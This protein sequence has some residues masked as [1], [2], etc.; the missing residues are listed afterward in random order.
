[1]I[2]NIARWLTS[3]AESVADR[4]G[5]TGRLKIYMNRTE[6]PKGAQNIALNKLVAH[7]GQFGVQPGDVREAIAS[8]FP[9]PGTG[10]KVHLVV[11]TPYRVERDQ[12]AKRVAD[13]ENTGKQADFFSTFCPALDT[14]LPDFEYSDTIQ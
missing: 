9:E 7:L 3:L 2:Q 12:L 13:I 4:N 11:T 8:L 14:I 5:K 6:V 10:G 1:M